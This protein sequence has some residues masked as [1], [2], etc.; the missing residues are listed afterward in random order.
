M[1]ASVFDLDQHQFVSFFGI[2]TRINKQMTNGFSETE[3]ELCRIYKYRARK[4][5]LYRL[6]PVGE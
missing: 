6:R 2:Q 1:S 5:Q 3:A 4:Q